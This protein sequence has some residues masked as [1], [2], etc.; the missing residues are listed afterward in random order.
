MVYF[1][2]NRGFSPKCYSFDDSVPLG[3]FLY[4][5]GTNAAA[6]NVEAARKG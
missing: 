4:Q 3:I 6:R 5:S 2:N 1:I